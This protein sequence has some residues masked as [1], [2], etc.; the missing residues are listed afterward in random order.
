MHT[1]LCWH[2][3]QC[4]LCSHSVVSS[5]LLLIFSEMYPA[6]LNRLLRQP[7]GSAH[8]HA[9]AHTHTKKN[10]FFYGHCYNPHMILK[11]APL[12]LL[13][14]FH[15]TFL[16]GHQVHIFQRQQKSYQDKDNL[17]WLLLVLFSITLALCQFIHLTFCNSLLYFNNWQQVFSLFLSPPRYTC[18]YRLSMKNCPCYLLGCLDRKWIGT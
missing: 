16:H 2:N 1:D 8:S 11:D 9:N 17:W 13:C 7:S 5:R 6:G 15:W 4:C 3:K 14:L 12:V 18:F 10:H